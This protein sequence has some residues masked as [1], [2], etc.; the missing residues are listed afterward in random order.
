MALNGDVAGAWR[1]NFAPLSSTNTM[2]SFLL[3]LSAALLCRAADS[4]AGRWE[5][6]AHIPGIEMRLIVDI[7]LD[8]NGAWIGSATLP[9]FDAK[10]ASLADIS[11]ANGKM[12]FTIKSVLGGVK[13]AG[14]IEP[15]GTFAGEIEQAGNKA[16]C[17]LR[18]T[19]AAQVEPSRVSTAVS[20]ELEGEWQGELTVPGNHFHVKL[21][22]ANHPAGAATAQFVIKG[23]QETNLPVD[24]VTQEGEWLTVYCH[25]Y[26]ISYEAR[27]R[28]GG[29]EIAGVFS[30]GGF[31]TP[32]P[33]RRAP[34]THP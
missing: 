6:A 25:E 7:A 12:A 13:I 14:Q 3:L 21:V 11:A 22:L 8:G 27:V 23:K 17:T 31:E 29:D 30:Q 18:R 4:P 34:E 5:G 26:N 15:D 33:L 2:H 24:L 16:P 28:A 19:G 20:K 9:G 32:V 10:G 1:D